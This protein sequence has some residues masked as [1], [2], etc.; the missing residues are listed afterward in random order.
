MVVEAHYLGLDQVEVE[1]MLNQLYTEFGG[2]VMV[3]EVKG[4]Y[5][6]LGDKEVLK[7][8]DLAIEPGHIF[9]LVGKTGLAKPPH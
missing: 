3:I 6:R 1:E 2:V 7:N 5:K 4:L 9:G 8:I